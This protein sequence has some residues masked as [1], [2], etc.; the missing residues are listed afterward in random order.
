MKHLTLTAIVAAMCFTGSAAI[1]QEP[2]HP[3]DKSPQHGSQASHEFIDH[4]TIAG[5]AEVQLGKLAQERAS[6]PEV[7]AFGQMMVTDHTKAGNALKPIAA[8]L[9]VNQPTQLDQQHKELA[10]RLSKLRG[11]EFDRE[12]INAMVTGHEK[13]VSE[14]KTRAGNRMTSTEPTADR[15]VPDPTTGSSDP[16]VGTTRPA[17]APEPGV[18]GTSGSMS[19]PGEEKLTDWAA[20]TLPTAQQHLEKA[21]ELQQKIGTR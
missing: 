12:Y 3:A 11:A 2:Q 1:A 18:A 17:P 13:V 7:K 8:Q 16:R 20:K 15:P 14:L 10:D 6:N 4:L 5:M 9:R 19:G 21:R